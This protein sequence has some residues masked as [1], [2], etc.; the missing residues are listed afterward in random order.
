M[1]QIRPSEVQDLFSRVRRRGY[2]H[3]LCGMEIK[4][5]RGF[6]DAAIRFDFPV[7]ALVG[8]NGAGKTTVLGAAGLI[9]EKV[10]PRRFF[11]RGGA[12]DNSMSGWR[13]E[14]DVLSDGASIPRTASYTEA[15]GDAR[16][17]KWNRKAVVRPVKVIG[18]THD[19]RPTP[20]P[21]GCCRLPTHLGV[22]SQD[23]IDQL[24]KHLSDIATL[25]IPP[26]RERD[27]PRAVKRARH[28]SYRVRKPDEPAS[29]RHHGPATIRLHSMNPRAA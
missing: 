26:R 14:Y 12:Y 11:A 13:V 20:A 25:L 18:V 9:Y 19:P 8:P 28:N 6:R 17:S 3:Y 10:Q 27:C 15:N 16:R 5:L 23:W 29:V 24:P 1:S 21:P 2:S 7:T 4:K 22:S